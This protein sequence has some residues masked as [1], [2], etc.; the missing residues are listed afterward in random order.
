LQALQF[1]PQFMHLGLQ[2]CLIVSLTLR[3]LGRNT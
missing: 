2:G 1:L 3:L